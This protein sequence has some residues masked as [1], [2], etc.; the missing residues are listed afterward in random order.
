M[1]VR[2]SVVA[3]SGDMAAS[4]PGAAIGDQP[5]DRSAKSH[6]PRL[7]VPFVA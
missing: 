3:S 4:L 6:L 2:M 5:A 7:G 1:A